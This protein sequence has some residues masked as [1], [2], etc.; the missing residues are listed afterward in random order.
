MG[1]VES[2]IAATLP[3]ARRALEPSGVVDLAAATEQLRRH[4]KR[5]RQELLDEAD[6]AGRAR[7]KAAP[8][9]GVAAGGGQQARALRCGAEG[10]AV[11]KRLQAAEKLT[12]QHNRRHAHTN[13]HTKS[14]GFRK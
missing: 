6:H 12:K 11:Q 10:G 2:G 9:A 14:G 4:T 3:P 13:V 8:E 1:W 7:R 5:A